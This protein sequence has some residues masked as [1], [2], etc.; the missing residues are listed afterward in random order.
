MLIMPFSDIVGHRQATEV[1]RRAVASGR[2]AQAYLFVGPPNVGKTTVAKLF[3]QALNCERTAGAAALEDVDPC[4]AC[5]NCLRIEE[6]NH[7]DF[8][9]LRPGVRSEIKDAVESEDESAEAE[10]REAGL[11]G[12]EP[13]V[14]QEGPSLFDDGAAAPRP[15]AKAKR[16]TGRI[17]LFIEMP[18]A[19]I[20][21]EQIEE[22]IRRANVKMS[23]DSRHRVLV[24]T[25]VDRVHH[26]AADRL[27]KTLEEPPPGTSFVLTTS[28]PASVNDT[29]I[30]RCQTIN[31]QPLS[32]A[33]MLEHLA[34][35]YPDEDGR[36]RRA[37]TA[38]AGGRFG[39]A[40][41]LLESPEARGVRDELL[42]LAAQ[43]ADASLVEALVMGERVVQ[44][45]E[46]WLEATDAVLTG[47]ADTGGE[48]GGRLAEL[49][50]QAVAALLAKSP[51][52]FKRIAMN[53]LL[54]VLQGW[55]RDLALLRV[56]PDSNL[57][58][59]S[60]WREK[61]TELAPGYSQ[62]GLQ[63]ASETIDNTRRDLLRHNA[64]MRLACEMLMCKL[65]ASRRR[66]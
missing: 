11:F 28:N 54:D 18:D 12:D 26:E 10:E 63:F 20:Y 36:A 9:L 48:E 30:S 46:R 40:V 58:T 47:R 19:L 53:Q 51:D 65:I 45:N 62:G 13:P 35:R 22:I 33:Q 4:G 7:P 52:R 27:L 29:I 23:P 6:E 41:Q 25:E 56:A 38:M 8:M 37:V 61:L 31:F 49:K 16:R 17:T 32:N 64:N 34:E 66:K 44:L 39:R 59:N 24:V 57:V 43:T 60:D 3:A 14:A 15:A 55:Y 5:H 2:V 50:A 42:Q 1:L 21:T